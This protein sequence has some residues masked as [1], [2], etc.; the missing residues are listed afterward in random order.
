MGEA[1]YFTKVEFREYCA[2]K[3]IR[4]ILLN[5]SEQELSY[6]V[7]RRKQ[8]APVIQGSESFTYSNGKT[9]NFDTGSSGKV[10]RNEKTGFKPV[11]LKD[12]DYE[13][14]VIFSYGIKLTL[15][16]M[17]GLLPY[18]N[19]LDFEPYRNKVMSMDD[20]RF[21]GYRDEITISFKATSD[22]YLPI[23]ELPM[24]YVYEEA[25]IW[26]SE[27]LYRYIIKTFF[28]GNK[29]LEQWPLSY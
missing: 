11:L 26:P 7:M 19:A 20:A 18:C 1:I 10:I 3:Y 23:I 28:E 27:K 24:D 17:E 15:E 21:C 2:G 12:E 25:Y 14:E 9:I 8:K 22:S 13:A 29:E 16:Q 4:A 6:Q 5:F